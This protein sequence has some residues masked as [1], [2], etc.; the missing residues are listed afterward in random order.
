M[1]V[2]TYSKF[3]LT[4]AQIELR[5][6]RDKKI[7]DILT[8]HLTIIIGSAFGIFVYILNYAKI[9][10]SNFFQ[11]LVQIFLFASIGILCVGIPAVLFKIAEIFY[12]KFIRERSDEH[13]LIQKYNQQREIFDFWKIRRDYSFWKILDGLSF[14][15]EVVNIY[16]HNGYE[17][18]KHSQNENN[19]DDVLLE[20]NGECIYLSFNTKALEV[21]DVKQV[22]ERLKSKE[23][24][25][26]QKLIII[27][28]K[29]FSKKI[30]E[31][32]RSKGVEAL[33]INGLIKLVRNVNSA[34]Q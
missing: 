6:S 33:D 24:S 2:P 30:M 10:P 20:K 11:M 21:N 34:T 14:Q 31:Y 1:K 3:G 12:F 16:L 13:K 32:M 8:H 28:Q 18:K 22:D 17:I 4:K 19:T 5:E 23:L 26:G 7:S 25:T 29:G 27:S 15:K 9:E